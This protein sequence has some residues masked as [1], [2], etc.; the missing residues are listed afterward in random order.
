VCAPRN[1]VAANCAGD[2]GNSRQSIFLSLIE[3]NSGDVAQWDK[4]V[5][6][7]SSH[8]NIVPIASERVPLLY[9]YGF[10]EAFDPEGR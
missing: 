7:V 3:R 1:G 5:A 10:D 8:R 2:N 6:L 4:L 9:P